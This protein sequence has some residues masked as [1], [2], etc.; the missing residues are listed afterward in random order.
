MSDTKFCKRCLQETNQVAQI[1]PHCKMPMSF[2]AHFKFMKILYCFLFFF[3]N[4]S[5]AQE[6]VQPQKYTSN[7]KQFSFTISPL[8][9]DGLSG[10][11][12]SLT[13]NDQKLWSKHLKTSAVMADVSSEGQ[14]ITC[15]YSKGLDPAYN[16]TKQ[17]SYGYMQ[18]T[19]FEQNGDVMWSQSIKRKPS[20]RM[21]SPPSPYCEQVL[22]QA[23]TERAFMWLFQDQ[24]TQLQVINTR[25]G[26]LLD[27]I[28]LNTEHAD[29]L[30]SIKDMKFHSIDD[31]D[32]LLLSV[33][34]RIYEEDEDGN[35]NYGYE[36]DALYYLLDTQGQI[37][38]HKSLMGSLDI[39]KTT[40]SEIAPLQRAYSEQDA[41]FVDS[42]AIQV[43]RLPKKFITEFAITDYNKQQLHWYQLTPKNK[44]K[45]IGTKPLVMDVSPFDVQ[46]QNQSS[47]KLLQNTNLTAYLD[48][49]KQRCSQNY[50]AI[51]L[52]SD[53]SLLLYEENN[54]KV[55]QFKD[56]QK[57]PTF[58]NV[59]KDLFKDD[60]IQETH[61]FVDHKDLIQINLGKTSFAQ[62]SREGELLGEKA[63]K[64]SCDPSKYCRL[65]IVAQR[66]SNK[67][68]LENSESGVMLIAPAEERFTQQAITQKD[69]TGQW[70]EYIYSI[71]NDDQGR[72][73][74]AGRYDDVI[75]QLYVLDAKAQP[76]TTL[77][78]GSYYLNGITMAGEYI[79]ISEA[80]N[81]EIAVLNFSGDVVRRFQT[82]NN[83]TPYLLKASRNEL[84]AITPDAV[85]VYDISD[86]MGMD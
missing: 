80:D 48:V 73:L 66:N 60:S 59:S 63:F 23:K 83:Q 44:V 38:W 22:I 77:F 53:G 61:M 11:H 8:S 5:Y 86:I 34:G 82:S 18:L 25:T 2:A 65:N 4:Q 15:A 56:L 29:K 49:D 43:R 40:E 42:E 72:L 26:A 85:L 64:S 67:L 28:K 35:G 36:A 31:S 50:E 69:S 33:T 30:T 32:L 75:S 84:Y 14:V 12:Y 27:N 71:Q 10:A 19:L 9:P 13:N 62:Y 37:I 16:Y 68:W 57:P 52:L 45:S 1:C 76:I 51:D 39:R 21:H 78:A 79:F 55:T 7:N 81:D 54:H 24:Q 17:S 41:Y 74:M 47:P 20:M 70:Y 46:V 58:F 6:I 3:A